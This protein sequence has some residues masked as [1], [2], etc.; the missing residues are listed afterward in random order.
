MGCLHISLAGFSLRC[1]GSRTND[2]DR[3]N[4]EI[5]GK[6]EVTG[7]LDVDGDLTVWGGLSI[8]GY[9]YAQFVDLQYRKN[10]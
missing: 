3:K 8:N 2:R 1:S 7:T 10:G 5:F 4:V 9:L 6:L